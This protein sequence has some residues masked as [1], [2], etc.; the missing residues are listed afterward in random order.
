MVVSGW[1]GSL[2]SQFVCTH[3][4]LAFHVPS[5][6]YYTAL[7]SISGVYP[8]CSSLVCKPV[9]RYWYSALNLATLGHPYYAP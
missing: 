4:Y 7:V 2:V 6:L 9:V 8:F 3:L 5:V 1:S